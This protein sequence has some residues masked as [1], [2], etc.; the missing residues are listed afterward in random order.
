MFVSTLL[1]AV[2]PFVAFVAAAPIVVVADVKVAPVN[3]AAAVAVPRFTVDVP[4]PPIANVAVTVPRAEVDNVDRALPS[5]P[6]AVV[7]AIATLKTDVAAAL[8]KVPL[9]GI[10]ASGAVTVL[11]DVK[12]AI[13]AFISAVGGVGV[14][15]RDATDVVDAAPTEL[16]DTIANIVTFAH[17]LPADVLADASVAPLLATIDGLLATVLS[18]VASV[19]ATVVSLLNGLGVFSLLSALGLPAILG[20]VSGLGLPVSL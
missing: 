15:V 8:A 6:P 11:A 18:I 10:T 3:V 17:S 14:V 2:L 5:L 19:L 9:V 1:T 16:A 4:I 20:I 7:T 12:S 13:L